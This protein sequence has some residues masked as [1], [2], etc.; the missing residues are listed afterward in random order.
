[1]SGGI[2]SVSVDSWWVE[3]LTEVLNVV[4]HAGNWKGGLDPL[5]A[6][7]VVIKVGEVLSLVAKVII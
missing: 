4:G 5:V 2:P 3:L 6:C 1:V 7:P